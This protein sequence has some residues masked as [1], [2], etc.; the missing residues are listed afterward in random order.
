[1]KVYLAKFEKNDK[2][3]YK[4]GHTKWFQSHKRF[5]DPQYDVFDRVSILNDINIQHT[6]A[7]V[8]REEAE[9]VEGCLRAFFPKNFRLEQHFITEEKVFDGLSGITEMFILSEGQTETFVVDIFNRVK[10][11]V[12]FVKNE[13]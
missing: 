5:E 4:I 2:V 1:M 12:G 8:A 10:R 11:N 3:A 6:D 13:R 9:L 7:R